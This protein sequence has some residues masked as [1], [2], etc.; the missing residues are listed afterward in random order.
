M[1]EHLSK[2]YIEELRDLDEPWPEEGCHYLP[3]FFVL[4]DSETTPLRI[5]FAA[6]AG[7]VSLNDCLYTGPCLLNN[8]LELLVRFRFPQYAFVADI[9]RA[10]LNIKL[11][12]EDRPFVRFLW[13][14]DND[15]T[16]E[17]CVY[18]YTTIVFGHTSSPM[19]LGAVLLE[20]L[21]KYSHPVAVDISQKL[22][23]DN[24]LSGAPTE[25]EAIAYFHK[26]R[27]IM[28]EGHFVLRQW[29][30]NSKALQDQI[31][32]NNTGIK[33]QANSLLGLQWD[34]SKDCINFPVKNF[35]SPIES[36]TK[37]K[38]LS[39]AS[40][41]FDPLGLVLPVCILARLFIAEL[42]DEKFGWD[43]PLPPAKAKGWKNIEHELN[44]AS[45]FQFPR[46]ADFDNSRPIYL[47]V[48]ADAS[49]SVMGAVAYISQGTQCTLVGSKS[50]LAPRGKKGLTIPQLEL[51]A[52]L[53]GAQFCNNLLAILKKEF[54]C[55]HVHLW[56]DSEISL[57]WLSSTRK[58]KQFVQNKVD[59]I[60]RL[61]DSS[62][63]GHT[64]SDENPADIVSRGCS[65]QSLQRSPLWS[66]GPSWITEEALWPKWPKAQPPTITTLI[67]VAEQQ[68]SETLIRPSVCNVIELERFNHYSRLLASTVYVRRFCSRT[69]IKEPPSTAELETAELE[70]ILSQQHQHFA[71]VLTYLTSS[72]SSSFEHAPAIVRQLNLFLD[73][74][75]I[76]RTKGRFDFDSSLILL[77]QHSRF[78]DLLILDN[79]QQ[80]HHIGVGGTIVA[81]R[82]RFWVPS[83]R[84]ATRNLL[85]KCLKCKRVTGRHY[86][87]PMSAELPTFRVDTSSRP[88][89]NIGADSLCRAAVVRT[90]KGC[91]TRSIVKLYPLEVQAG[92]HSTPEESTEN[93]EEHS[94][95]NTRPQRKAAFVARDAIHAQLIDNLLD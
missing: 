10:F 23:V 51:S 28:H 66:Q 18:T 72:S 5:V 70:W 89:S 91:T 68:L 49:K 85:R 79:H 61:F 75:G 4:K 59:A 17:I 2:G 80:L 81:L 86:P 26:A 58:L 47:H 30:T 82:K 74:K 3:H 53:L 94:N 90:S 37:R 77:P 32:S 78:T 24:L 54:S 29:S 25:A 9:Q 95:E 22:Y 44:I 15:P 92:S 76:I 13:Y 33:S 67:A 71:T 36:L 19:S 88:F 56:T 83:A 52:M 1:A 63:W 35:D 65:A 69:R 14:K 40:Q 16:K 64:A 42:W 45:R 62:L 48:F 6:N 50:K 93:N 38:V 39:I 41:L 31:S 87:L 57:Y 60:N 73:E 43:Q 27:E 11:K 46:W 12:E 34:A 21:Q 8:L 7:K 20:H 84:S 55:I